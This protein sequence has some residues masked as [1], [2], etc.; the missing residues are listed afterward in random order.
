M[1][2]VTVPGWKPN[3]KYIPVPE[4]VDLKT[5]TGHE[6][7]GDDKKPVTQTFEQFVLARLLD[8]RF[9]TGV[10]M[11]LIALKI[12]DQIKKANGLLELEDADYKELLAAVESPS[13]NMLYD[14]RWT[15]CLVPFMTAICEAK[16]KPPEADKADEGEQSADEPQDDEA[17]SADK[18]T[19]DE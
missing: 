15:L 5:N 2:Y 8:K 7:M 11:I 19:I 17:L 14:P 10:P 9:A 13:D 3:M 4:T 18:L 6:V 16:N 1:S 12:S